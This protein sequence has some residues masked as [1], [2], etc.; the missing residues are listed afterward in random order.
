[1]PYTLDQ[2]R[3]FQTFRR[4]A[5]RPAVPPHGPRFLPPTSAA[6][7]RC[8]APEV[9]QSPSAP[10]A[11]EPPPIAACRVREMPDPR[12]PRDLASPHRGEDS[13]AVSRK[14]RPC[15]SR[16]CHSRNLRRRMCGWPAAG[17]CA[18]GGEQRTHDDRSKKRKT[19]ASSW[20]SCS[21]LMLQT[22]KKGPKPRRGNLLV[23]RPAQPQFGP[24]M[25]SASISPPIETLR[26]HPDGPIRPPQSGDRGETSA[27]PA[28]C[29]SIAQKNAAAAQPRNGEAECGEKKGWTAASCMKKVVF[30][31]VGVAPEKQVIVFRAARPSCVCLSAPLVAHS[32]RKGS[33]RCC[34]W[35]GK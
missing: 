33:A 2:T 18:A 32:S 15:T 17:G 26:R 35:L 20:H 6:R 30:G 24:S 4:P 21:R 28:R 19:V 5:R 7:Q 8:F 34:W 25:T 27:P 10:S 3:S 1:V 31:R 29:R 9:H 12:K 13:Q 11:L 16:S 14:Q 23:A 22:A